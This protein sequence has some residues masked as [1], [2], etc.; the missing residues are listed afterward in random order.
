MFSKTC[1]GPFLNFTKFTPS[2]QIQ[3]NLLCRITNVP[4]SVEEEMYF[5]I[6]GKLFCYLLHHFPI[7]TGL[8]CEGEANYKYTVT[9][10]RSAFAKA[11]FKQPT[12]FKRETLESWF[13]DARVNNDEDAVK[14]VLVYLVASLLLNNNP[15]VSLLEFFVNLVD[16]LETFNNFPWGKVV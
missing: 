6:C 5:E 1:F 8:K 10:E 3:H 9:T 12:K 13:L 7:I 15:T 2:P 16:N 4:G 11:Y 14:L